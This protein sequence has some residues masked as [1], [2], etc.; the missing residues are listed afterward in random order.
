MQMD[1]Y[2][3]RL[4][5]F[6]T[7]GIAERG[8]THMSISKGESSA[9]TR[10]HLE[11]INCERDR[12]LTLGQ[13]NVPYQAYGTILRDKKSM[14]NVEL[15][16]T[17]GQLQC[18]SVTFSK[19]KATRSTR[20]TEDFLLLDYCEFQLAV[21]GNNLSYLEDLLY[22]YDLTFLQIYQPHLFLAPRHTE[23]VIHEMVWRHNQWKDKERYI[24]IEEVLFH[25]LATE[26]TSREVIQP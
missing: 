13:L 21:W 22:L 7:Y 20:E 4:S 1:S 8:A 23:P 5:Q 24:P 15:F 25:H 19:L 12:K 16:P 26:T 17:K 6:E 11:V 10:P 9:P 3:M 2:N 18:Y 14:V